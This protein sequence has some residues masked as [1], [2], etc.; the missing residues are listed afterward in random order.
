[1]TAPTHPNDPKPTYDFHAEFKT[2]LR[3]QQE[4]SVIDVVRTDTGFWGTQSHAPSAPLRFLNKRFAPYLKSIQVRDILQEGNPRTQFTFT[5]NKEISQSFDIVQDS[6]DTMSDTSSGVLVNLCLP[7]N[8]LTDVVVEGTQ[9]ALE[10]ALSDMRK[11]GCTVMREH[12]RKTAIGFMHR[13][14]VC[15][16]GLARIA[17]LGAGL[18]FS[19][20]TAQYYFGVTFYCGDEL[21]AEIIAVL[22]QSDYRGSVVHESPK[23]ITVGCCDEVSCTTLIHELQHWRVVGEI[24][25]DFQFRQWK[26]TASTTTE[27]GFTCVPK[28]GVI[29][30]QRDSV[31]AECVHGRLTAADVRAFLDGLGLPGASFRF[32]EEDQTR[33]LILS[34]LDLSGLKGAKYKLAV[35]GGTPIPISFRDASD[36]AQPASSG[37]AH[38]QSSEDADAPGEGTDAEAADGDLIL[39]PTAEDGDTILVEGDRIPVPAPLWEEAFDPKHAGEAAHPSIAPALHIG[40]VVEA[41][42]Y[43]ATGGSEP[44]ECLRITGSCPGHSHLWKVIPLETEQAIMREVVK[45]HG[46][47]KGYKSQV[48]EIEHQ[49]AKRAK[50]HSANST[51]I[52][53]SGDS[54]EDIEVARKIATQTAARWAEGIKKFLFDAATRFLAYPAARSQVAD[55]ATDPPYYDMT[56][57]IEH[58]SRAVELAHGILQTAKLGKDAKLARFQAEIRN[59]NKRAHTKHKLHTTSDCSTEPKRARH[60]PPPTPPQ[61]A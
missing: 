53:I 32:F 52:K 49:D 10:S 16:R 21:Q 13:L 3:E 18:I 25:S 12:K 40:S 58:S 55:P 57:M 4:F 30:V 46:P 9:C 60:L 28:F 1:M 35:H 37:P 15:N 33:K 59:A 38:T 61:G 19:L 20:P 2:L 26:C 27:G 11:T 43:D 29:S 6:A 31:I 45:V 22:S 17:E 48:F 8:S 23:W 39:D 56:T 34:G 44:Y 7:R 54:P 41:K 51:Q 14:S 42:I 24:S 36:A 47:K 50:V 5:F